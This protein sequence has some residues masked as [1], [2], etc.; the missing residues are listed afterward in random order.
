M[1]RERVGELGELGLRCR[2]LDEGRDH[3]WLVATLQQ[4]EA[5][6]RLVLG[7]VE[8]DSLRGERRLDLLAREW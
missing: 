2:D 1:K 6:D 4:D 5:V 8:R 7:P 3:T